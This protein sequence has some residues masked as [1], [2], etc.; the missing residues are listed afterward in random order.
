M[1]FS[2]PKIMGI[3]NLT[4]DSFFS[5]SRF[6]AEKEILLQ[7]EKM[8]AEGADIIDLGAFSS[9]PNSDFISL[10]EEK[11]RLLSPLKKIIQEF[12]SALL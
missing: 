7:V 11:E 1:D 10:E 2:T 6:Q 3:V 5:G 4:P 12:P 9:R 8:L